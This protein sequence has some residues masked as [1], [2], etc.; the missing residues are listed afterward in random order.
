M[1]AMIDGL[2]S[3]AVQTSKHEI[4]SYLHQAAISEV[5]GVTVDVYDHPNNTTPATAP[6]WQGQQD[7]NILNGGAATSPA[8]TE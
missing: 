8:S 3:W 6:A 2:G 7:T 1:I 5:S 4:E